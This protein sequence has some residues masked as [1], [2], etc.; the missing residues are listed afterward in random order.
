MTDRGADSVLIG[1]SLTAFGLPFVVLAPL[2]G[3]LAGRRSPLRWAV[4]AL[5]VCAVFMASYGFVASPVVITVLG[6]FEACAQAVVIPGGYAAAAGVFP[7]RWAASGQGWFSG[8]GTA[9]AGA[10]AVLGAPVYAGLGAGAVFAGGAV[11]SVAI[12]LAG[13]VVGRRTGAAGSG[14]GGPKAS[15]HA[16]FTGGTREPDCHQPA[17]PGS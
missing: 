2:G 16:V 4:A 11:A 1:L 15:I 9:A 13:L 17:A 3:R 8:A 12:A 7:D 5:C 6:M 14:G 10:A